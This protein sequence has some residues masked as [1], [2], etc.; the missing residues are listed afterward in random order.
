MT[1]LLSAVSPQPLMDGISAVPFLILCIADFPISIVAFGVMF[2]SGRYGI[3][4]LVVW[5]V[6]GTLWWWFLGR[7]IESWILRFR[8]RHGTSPEATGLEHSAIGS[9]PAQGRTW[10]IWVAGGFA[11][12]AVGLIAFTWGQSTLEKA[13]NGG[14]IGSFAL[15]PDG[16]AILLSRREKDWAFLYIVSLDSGAAARLTRASAGFESS[17]SF[18]PDGK[19]IAYALTEEQ[20]GHSR[21]FVMDTKARDP[22]PLFPSTADADD[23]FPKYAPNGRIYFARAGYFG[24]YSPIARPSL[25]EWDV[26]TVDPDGKDVRPL[27]NQ[28]FYQMSE[29]SLSSDGKRILF[30]VETE[31]GSQLQ[32]YTPDST[33]P[34]AV[35]QPHV[36]N[37]PTHPIYA[38]AVLTPDGDSVLF[39]AA[40][41]G[42][43]VFDYDVYRFDLTTKKVVKLTSANGYATNLCLSPDG[44]QALFLRWSSKYGKLPTV[45]HMYQLELETKRLTALPITGTQ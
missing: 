14:A 29:P 30:S 39:L 2:S 24:Q 16:R 38:G 44:R 8:S 11:V 35:L 19:Q 41:E 40:S 7:S 27:T 1:W 15:S 12:L 42:A 22:R 13:R 3:A 45:S 26:Y 25:H 9:T 28:R 10:G 23:L 21:I 20:G 5:A 36:P 6:V 32:I 4:A 34:V 37:E 17:P 31:F 43:K 33:T 18:S